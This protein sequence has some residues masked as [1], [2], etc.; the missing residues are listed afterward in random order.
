[1]PK[2]INWL[3]IERYTITIK[4]N[5]GYHV[6][7]TRGKSKCFAFLNGRMVTILALKCMWFSGRAG[8]DASF[9]PQA[10]LVEYWFRN[11]VIFIV[12][13]SLRPCYI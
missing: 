5:D 2:T 11:S 3:N 4:Q 12:P 10:N 9:A 1:M 13:Q 7:I 6:S 8:G